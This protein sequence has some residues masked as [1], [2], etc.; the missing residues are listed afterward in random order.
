MYST[1]HTES[2]LNGTAFF[3]FWK[4]GIGKRECKKKEKK[5]HYLI[6]SKILLITHLDTGRE[7]ERKR[8]NEISIETNA[9]S[10]KNW[11]EYL[12]QHVRGSQ[13]TTTTISRSLKEE[14]T[15]CSLLKRMSQINTHTHAEWKRER[16]RVREKDT[17]V[18]LS[19]SLR[20]I[21][22]ERTTNSNQSSSLS[23]ST[24][25]SRRFCF[26]SKFF[27]TNAKEKE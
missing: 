12:N 14:M 5:K 19:S 1:G 3:F 22:A 18:L 20:A 7:A 16:E 25:S 21:A 15:K 8:V 27:R 17:H 24:Q 4:M 23:H 10:S 26:S 6:K 11:M 9:K 13:S 2:A